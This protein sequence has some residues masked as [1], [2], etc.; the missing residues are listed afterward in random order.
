MDKVEGVYAPIAVPKLGTGRAWAV[1][2]IA[3]LYFFYIYIQMTKFNSIGHD[4]MLD[5]KIGSTGLGALSSVYFWGN[6][7]FLFPAGLLLDRFSSK[8]ILAISMI[9]TV[10]CTAIF[11]FTHNVH[12]ASW[13]FL[14]IGIVG[15]FA[16]LLPLRLVSRW[17][18]S[19]KMA[20]AS[21]LVITIG[22]FGA[23]ISQSPLVWLTN[24]VGWRNAM[25][26]NAGLGAFLFIVMM[27]VIKDFPEG[28]TREMSHEQVTSIRFL[29][30]SLRLSIMNRQNWLFGLYT[31]FLNLP[32]FIFGA[33]FGLR[34]LEQ[35]QGLTENQAAIVIDL[36]FLG[37]MLGAPILGWISDRIRLR[38]LPMI[39][40][41]LISLALIFVSMYEVNV[42]FLYASVLFLSIGFFT[43]SQVITYPVVAESNKPA[44]VGTGFGM[45]STLIMSGGSLGIPLFGWLLDLHWKGATMH[46]V[47]FHSIAEYQ[48]ALWMIPI[49]F[50]LGIIAVGFGKET[51]CKHIV[52]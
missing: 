51:C 28:M 13:C 16:L 34:Y 4:L 41:A 42:S 26:W 45:A 11:A 30:H 46:S 25:L 38:K 2:M 10:I 24:H 12:Q 33:A 6:I 15:A 49:A 8:K 39:I 43:S 27:I 22:F 7:I 18:P 50:I 48:F 35:M 32:I 5:F 52:K 20:L 9:V 3:A 21:G 37:A 17:F 14:F 36:M 23:M 40:S 29:L 47:P 31:C 1:C 19:E 44:I